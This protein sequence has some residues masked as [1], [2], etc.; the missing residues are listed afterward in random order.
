MA[1]EPVQ[2]GDETDAEQVTVYVTIS[3]DG[4]PLLGTD[5]AKTPLARREDHGSVL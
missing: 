4:V 3:N 1:K 2:L 5:A